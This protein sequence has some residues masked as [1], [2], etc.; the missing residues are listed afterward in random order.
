MSHWCSQA[1]EGAKFWIS[2][3]RTVYLSNFSRLQLIQNSAP[4]VARGH[5]NTLQSG[6]IFY[7]SVFTFKTN[8]KSSLTFS[9]AVYVYLGKLLEILHKLMHTSA[10]ISNYGFSF[11]FR[12]LQWFSLRKNNKR[13]GKDQKTGT[14]KTRQKMTESLTMPLVWRAVLIITF[15]WIVHIDNSA[16]VWCRETGY[17]R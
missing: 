11:S 17:T 15:S 8:R 10:Y 2:C 3:K 14:T 13:E 7:E 16:M 1:T 12:S 9:F 4:S 5:L 6:M